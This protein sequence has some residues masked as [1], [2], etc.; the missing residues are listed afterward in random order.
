MFKL[1]SNPRKPTRH[2]KVLLTETYTTHAPLIRNTQ[3]FDIVKE[4]FVD[5]RFLICV[6][7]DALVFSLVDHPLGKRSI[8][9]GNFCHTQTALY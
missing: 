3:I 2:Q 9:P 5:A 4:E 6:E 1:V 8:S 7:V